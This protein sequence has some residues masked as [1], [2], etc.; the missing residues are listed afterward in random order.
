MIFDAFGTL[1]QIGAWRSPYRQLQRLMASH[2]RPPRQDDVYTMLTTDVGL[3][4]FAAAVGVDILGEAFA[5][6]ELDLYTELSTVQLFD[7]ALPAIAALRQAGLKVGVCSNLAAPYAIPVRLLLPDLDSYS[8]SF[9]V[10]AV[11][12]D[13][14]IYEHA[15]ST[16]GVDAGRTLFVGDTPEA[17]V[18]GPERIGMRACL[19]DRQGEHG[20]SPALCTLGDLREIGALTNR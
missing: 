6:I 20:G 18:R 19:L 9:E 15:L 13:P 14:R 3:A 2:G 11:K 17:D 1:V 8:W 10:G 5:K 7:D 4:G 12:P 16:L